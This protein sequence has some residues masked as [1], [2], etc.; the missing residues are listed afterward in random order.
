VFVRI[1]KLKRKSEI[2]FLLKTLGFGRALRKIYDRLKN[3]DY[4]NKEA[5]ILMLGDERFAAENKI[6]RREVENL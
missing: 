1:S 3:A 6:F 5:V 2:T 4:I